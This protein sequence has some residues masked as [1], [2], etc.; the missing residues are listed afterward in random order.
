MSFPTFSDRDAAILADVYRLRYVSTAQVL[1][2]H[3]SGLAS[4]TPGYR[5]LTRLQSLGMIKAFTVPNVPERLFYLTDYGARYLA[6]LRGIGLDE[7]RL[8]RPR[9]KPPKLTGFMRHFVGVTDVRLSVEADVAA[10]PEASLPLWLPEYALK[11]N[12]KEPLL[13]LSVYS[14]ETLS[15]TPD[16]AFILTVG[17]QSRLYLLEYDRG[18][19]SLSNPDRGVLKMIRFYLAAR[20]RDPFGGLRQLVPGTAPG[21]Q[22]LVVCEAESRLLT[23]RRK[24]IRAL[25]E[26]DGSGVPW[27]WGAAAPL[28]R[29]LAHEWLPLLRS[30]TE[31]YRLDRQ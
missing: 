1:R 12:S 19:E 20:R 16:A 7:L 6:D 23:M 30:G 11:P 28:E 13:R 2:A 18:T 4:K 24:L 31:T 5:A 8:Y 22:L 14:N 29:P 27:V 17:G 25:P 26:T 9:R 21:F 3:F 15:H 10:R